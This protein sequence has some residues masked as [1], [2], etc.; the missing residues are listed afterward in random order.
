MVLDGTGSEQ[1]LPRVHPHGRPRGDADENLI[2]V[3]VPQPERETQIVANG[4]MKAKAAPLHRHVFVARRVV[5]R[6]PAIG[7]E[8][9]LVIPFTI[10]QL[11]TSV[12]YTLPPSSLLKPTFNAVLE[13]PLL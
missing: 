13:I 11:V 3:A 2:A 1:H 10:C 12:I 4:E 5:L 6:L 7:K 9:V 8:A